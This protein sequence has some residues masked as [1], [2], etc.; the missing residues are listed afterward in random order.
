[1]VKKNDAQ[2]ERWGGRVCA[3]FSSGIA[4]EA[5]TGQRG[6]RALIM[7]KGTRMARDQEDIS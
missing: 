4:A 3:E 1:M 7:L 2:A 5:G 6:L